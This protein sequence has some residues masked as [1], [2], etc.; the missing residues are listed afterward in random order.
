MKRFFDKKSESLEDKRMMS[1][2]ECDQEPDDPDVEPDEPVYTR[3]TINPD[4]L[5]RDEFRQ[6]MYFET[7]V[8]MNNEER[9]QYGD[10]AEYRWRNFYAYKLSQETP[11]A[12]DGNVESW[13]D[14][15]NSPY[16][17]EWTNMPESKAS[18]YRYGN[19]ASWQNFFYERKLQGQY[20]NHGPVVAPKKSKEELFEEFKKSP[21]YATWQGLPWSIKVRYD[22]GTGVLWWNYY[23]EKLNEEQA[24]A[25]PLSNNA[26]YAQAAKARGHKYREFKGS[27]YSIEWHGMPAKK[28]ASYDQGY[29]GLGCLGKLSMI[30]D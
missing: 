4:A 23:H 12:Y 15:K 6:S 5:N 30:V 25:K 16:F 9:S 26:K 22:D 28:K 2:E 18:F 20:A 19:R 13:A 8:N 17:L 7:W 11:I 27:K 29:G 21:H 1:K 24:K 3:P 14:F 10:D